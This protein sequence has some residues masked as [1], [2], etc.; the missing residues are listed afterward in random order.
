MTTTAALTSAARAGEAELTAAR[1]AGA[2]LT[3]AGTRAAPEA[4]MTDAAAR[5]LPVAAAPSSVT[6][7]NAAVAAAIDNDAAAHS[8][9]HPIPARSGRSSRM[10]N[11]TVS[12]TAGLQL[13]RTVVCDVRVNP[14]VGTMP[15]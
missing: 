7:G 15:G 1:V 3:A 2:L 6:V 11:A 10:G 12:L 13:I 4:A 14:P 5:M 9:I 8:P